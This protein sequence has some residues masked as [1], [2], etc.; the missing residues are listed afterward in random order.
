M[1]LISPKW[2]TTKIYRD[3]DERFQEGP[4]PRININCAKKSWNNLEV[5]HP[6]RWING[7]LQVRIIQNKSYFLIFYT[8]SNWLNF[9]V[10]RRQ[11]ASPRS[12]TKIKWPKDQV[13]FQL[14]LGKPTMDS[15]TY[16]RS[17]TLWRQW[18][19]YTANSLS[20][21]TRFNLMRRSGIQMS[22]IKGK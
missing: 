22:K 14:M 2:K 9:Y 4:Q 12:E 6:S 10:Q 19:Q 17:T 20:E 8:T 1:D 13:F 5:N 18:K 16:T 7:K 3:K 11:D 21:M 15:S